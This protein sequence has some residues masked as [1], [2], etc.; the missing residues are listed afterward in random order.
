MTLTYIVHNVSQGTNYTFMSLFSSKSI[1]KER[2]SWG[3]FI[4]SIT[5]A[6][7][8][9]LSEISVTSAKSMKN[10]SGSGARSGMSR[11]TIASSSQGTSFSSPRLEIFV[12]GTVDVNRDDRNSPAGGWSGSRG[13]AIY[14][15][16]VNCRVIAGTSSLGRITTLNCS[17]YPLHSSIMT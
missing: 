10:N 3:S 14:V 5:L 8:D 7:N 2:I 13:P 1:E 11:W 12:R 6:S 4:S 17:L 15:G 16:S 9:E